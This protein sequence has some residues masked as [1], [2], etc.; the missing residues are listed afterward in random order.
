M[1][2]G[3]AQ[4]LRSLEGQLRVAEGGCG[5][6]SS[7]GYPAEECP[8]GTVLWRGFTI[9]LQGGE[10]PSQL[11]RVPVR[12]GLK[13]LESPTPS[14]YGEVVSLTAREKKDRKIEPGPVMRSTSAFMWRYLWGD[15][16]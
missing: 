9:L 10:H 5:G 6:I 14:F 16:E 4:K 8:D 7:S 1:S 13:I 3:D 2:Y 11:L 15:L 12:H